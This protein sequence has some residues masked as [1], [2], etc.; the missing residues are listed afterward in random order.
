MTWRTPTALA[1]ALLWMSLGSPIPA[2]PPQ[3]PQHTEM[4]VGAIRWDNWTP[5]SRHS[6][7]VLDPKA[8]DR[9]PFFAL[10]DRAGRTRLL[11]GTAPVAAAENLYGRAAG[12]DYWLFNYYAPTGSFG[13]TAEFT[14]RINRALTAYR[15]LPDR[16]GMRFALLLQ[17]SYPARDLDALVTLLGAALSDRDYVRL[18]DGS[19]PLFAQSMRGWEATLG[20]EAAVRAFFTTLRDRV[21]DGIGRPVRLVLVGSDLA[22]IDRYVGGGAPFEVFTSYADA[23]PN[24]G[25]VRPATDCEAG[26]REFWR[27]A[28]ALDKRFMPNVTLGWDMRTTLSHPDQMYGRSTTPGTCAP[29]TDAQ[30]IAYI[31]AA[32][33]TARRGAGDGMMPGLVFYA[34]N[35]LSEGGWIVPTRR[36]GARR[37]GVLARALNRADRTPAQAVLT[38]PD[39]GDKATHTDEWPCPPAMRVTAESPAVADADMQRLHS[40]R[41]TRRT[42]TRLLE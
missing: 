5:E 19:V 6:D 26:G 23:P 25:K 2:A 18:A 20:T 27:R 29:A 41:W 35:E 24:D 9:V 12:I 36:E 42:C 34:W 14:T 15:E 1:A 30:W 37:I 40:G 3:A 4:L 32:R 11:G 17:Q 33:A 31:A 39:D 16:G 7:V 10:T 21:A 38:Y 8:T 22:V 13:R 28:L